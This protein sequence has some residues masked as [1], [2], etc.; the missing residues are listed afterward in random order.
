MAKVQEFPGG[1]AQVVGG[2][3]WS[4]GCGTK[5][6]CHAGADW[7]WQWKKKCEG[8]GRHSVEATRTT[9][10]GGAWE[11]VMTT[12]AAVSDGSSGRGAEDQKT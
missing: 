11:E 4:D 8:G 1:G 12:M 9:K 6:S 5:G 7:R 2:G 3:A 10:M